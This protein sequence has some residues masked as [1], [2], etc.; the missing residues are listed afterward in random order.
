VNEGTLAR[1]D[2]AADLADE[3]EGRFEG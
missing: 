2:C 3:G 1:T